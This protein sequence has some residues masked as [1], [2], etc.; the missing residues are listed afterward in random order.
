MLTVSGRSNGAPWTRQLSIKIVDDQAGIAKLWG[1]ERIGELARQRNFGGDAAASEAE[2][3][4]LALAHHLVSDFTSLV[5]V[6]LTPVRVPGAPLNRE[7][8][9]TSA[10]EG[11]YWAQST[12]FSS[13]ATPAPVLILVG[14]F[15]L[16]LALLLWTA[17]GVRNTR[18]LRF[19]L[20][21]R[22]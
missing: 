21:S 15:S 3:V 13:T 10:P 1:R 20:R 6:D 19:A 22:R 16:A 2:I 14:M 7:Q 8:A 18:A 4:E 17:P 9:A 5:A 11:S 12:G